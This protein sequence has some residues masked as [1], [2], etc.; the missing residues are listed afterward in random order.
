VELRGGGGGFRQQGLSRID[1]ACF[2]RLVYTSDYLPVVL[3]ARHLYSTCHKCVAV[4]SLRCNRTFVCD[5]YE[6]L[7]IRAKVW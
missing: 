6:A 3:P 2:E 5:Q 7:K 1:D 4:R